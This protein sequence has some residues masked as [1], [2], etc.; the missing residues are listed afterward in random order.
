MACIDYFIMVKQ[1]AAGQIDF[2][3]KTIGLETPLM[4][5]VRGGSLQVLARLLNVSANPF[6]LNGMGQSALD[7]AAI[8]QP[9]FVG[10]IQTA[11]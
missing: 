6:M 5:A 9:A 4:F 10:P 11:I 3:A 1:A 7:L 2:D 8:Q